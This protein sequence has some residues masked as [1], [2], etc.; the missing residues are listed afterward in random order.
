V[1]HINAV[2]FHTGDTVECPATG[3]TISVQNTT[4]RGAWDA[5]ALR[6]NPVTTGTG[7][8]VVR[9]LTAAG[10][11]ANASASSCYYRFYFRFATK[12]GSG[13]EPVARNEDSGGTAQVELGLNSSGNLAVYD[14][15]DGGSGGSPVLH[16]TGSTVL[17][18][19]TW[20]RV[21][22]FCDPSSG[23]D[24]DY[25]LKIDGATEL[26]GTI[27][28]NDQSFAGN[29]RL[30]KLANRNGQTVDYFYSTVAIRDDAYPGDARH[31]LLAPTA[32][33][34]YQTWS[35][36]AGAGSHWQNVEE[37]PHDSDTT[38]LLS[39]GVT[40]NAETEA[41][42]DT[43]SL[44]IATVNCAKAMAVL[45]RNGASNGAVRLRTRSASTD[46]D[47][48]SNFATTTS[49]SLCARVLDTDPATAAAWTA[50]GLDGV[51][52]GAVEQSANT[53]RLTACY[54]AVDY[55]HDPGGG[56]GSPSTAYNLLL[57]G[58]G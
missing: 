13:Y 22:L 23:T 17:S 45:K 28:G 47:L 4:T 26:T 7:F 15:Y 56:G 18:S 53:S 43:G 16:A 8:A 46:S 51:E 39:T 49:Y 27:A 24:L 38:Y 29:L 2:G 48:G 57:L 12:A 21:E 25:V 37:V 35:I 33:G 31:S 11:A 19:G 1:G 55:V 3:G 52:V 44:S 14:A 30:G 10:A 34:N 5:Y 54:L 40:G 42:G 32:D 41:M 9:G 6:V 20:Y 36:G 58:V 50:S